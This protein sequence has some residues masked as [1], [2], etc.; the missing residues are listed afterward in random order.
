[1]LQILEMFDEIQREARVS[2]IAERLNFPQSSTSVL[3]KCLAQMGYLDYDAGSR[4]FLP[5]PRVALL[6]AWLD[7]G[8]VR[9]GSLVRMLEHLSERTGG[10]VILAARNAIFSQYVH[11]LQARTAMRFHVPTGTRRLV[12]WSATG[13]ALLADSPDAEISPL[14]R[15]TNAEAMAEQPPIQV[16][17]V[18]ANLARV[19]RDGH[20]FSR[21]LV[22]PGAGSIAV[23][24]PKRIDRKG[25]PLAVA[26]SG[27]V[28]EF[29]RREAHIVATIQDAIARFLVHMD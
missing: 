13:T 18:M 17:A 3:L 11:V 9:D 4:S 22:T 26:I 6:G 5:S 25:R 19:R 12:V 23:P 20:F 28:D 29:E 7:K 27:L 21:G 10:T 15:R 24:L 8:P 1:M 16:A 14:V 2:E